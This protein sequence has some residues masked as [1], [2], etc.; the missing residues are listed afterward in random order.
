MATYL[1]DPNM[2]KYNG[3][4]RM[5]FELGD[6]Q[7]DGGSDTCAL[8]DEEYEQLIAE[9]KTWRDKKI[10][11][12]KAIIARFSMM[13]DFHAG[14]MSIDFS[15]RYDRYKAMLDE[16]EKK[17]Q[18]ITANPASLGKGSA[19]GGHYFRLGMLNNPR[20]GLEPDYR[21]RR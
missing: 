19:D 18:Y 13:V 4:D 3:K 9:G 16:L 21:G 6:T 5:R 1:Y 20:V 11:C 15:V 14:G 8:C 10:A 7:I 17:G 12:L 2:L